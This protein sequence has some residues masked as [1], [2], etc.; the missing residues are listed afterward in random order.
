VIKDGNVKIYLKKYNNS[1]LM[2]SSLKDRLKK[3]IRDKKNKRS[4]KESNSEHEKVDSEKLFGMINEVNQMLKNNPNMVKKVSKCVNNI[5]E[6]KDLM[7]TLVSEIENN[8]KN[9]SSEMEDQVSQTLDN[10][11]EV[12]SSVATE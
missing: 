3:K 12:V 9:D 6:N 4:G 8:V 1:L 10:S 5:F 7:N 11:S 2:D